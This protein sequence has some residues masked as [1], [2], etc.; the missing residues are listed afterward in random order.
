MGRGLQLVIHPLGHSPVRSPATW[1]RQRRAGWTTYWRA[2]WASETPSWVSGAGKSGVPGTGG[3]WSAGACTRAHSQSVFSPCPSVCPSVPLFVYLVPLSVWPLSG[4]G[5]GDCSELGGSPGLRTRPG[6]CSGRVR[7]SRRVRGGG[8]GSHRRG[9]R[10]LWL[11]CVGVSSPGPSPL[12][13]RHS[14]TQDSPETRS[15]TRTRPSSET[16]AHLEAQ[17]GSSTQF[18]SETHPEPHPGSGTQVSSEVQPSSRTQPSSLIQAHSEA[19]LA[20]STQSESQPGSGTQVSPKARSCSRTKSAILPSSRTQLSSETQ[21]EFPDSPELQSCSKTKIEAQGSSRTQPSSVTQAHPKA[22]LGS[23]TLVV[24]QDQPAFKSQSI[25]GVQSDFRTQA[26]PKVQAGSGTQS[27]P[28]P[29]PC[30][31]TH[32]E[33]DCQPIPRAQAGSEVQPGSEATPRS[34]AWVRTQ[35]SPQ[36]SFCSE[37]KSTSRPHMGS[38]GGLGSRTQTHPDRKPCSRAQAD[39]GTNPD[40]AAQVVADPQPSRMQ[41][42]PVPE[43]HS[44]TSTNVK[45]QQGSE[46]HPSCQSQKPGSESQ[47][48]YKTAATMAWPFP[49][50]WS[51]QGGTDC[52]G[53]QGRSSKPLAA[54]SQVGWSSHHHTH[55]LK[56]SSTSHYAHSLTLLPP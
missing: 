5:G 12:P 21:P 29:E 26:S 30:S 40:A 24:S 16:Q 15:T 28:R 55:H 42:S 2:T 34:G 45:R 6:R 33:S 52:L 35:A 31:K 1:K 4:R 50:T 32:P 44:G 43:P 18:S 38:E 47:P 53:P 17:P 49:D 48:R 41:P 54:R 19:Q 23:V 39:T 11:A 37:T 46:H 7:L 14:T 25:P 8:V 13:Q 51:G 10:R 9:P 3:W 56:Q 22:Q 27:G 20:S 36:V